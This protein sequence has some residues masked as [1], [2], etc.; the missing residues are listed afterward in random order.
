MGD[1]DKTC[2]S[3]C[4]FKFIFIY[5]DRRER[6]S[7]GGAERE[8]ETESQVGSMLSARCPMQ[9]NLMNCEIMT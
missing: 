8:R 4:F 2:F 5:F 3:S 7:G 1:H 6:V 9:E